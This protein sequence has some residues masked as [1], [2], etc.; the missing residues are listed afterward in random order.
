MFGVSEGRKTLGSDFEHIWEGIKFKKGIHGIHG[1]LYLG[2]I[3]DLTIGEKTM[4]MVDSSKKELI[5]CGKPV[6]L[7]GFTLICGQLWKD[8]MK[9]ACSVCKENHK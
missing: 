4:D 2:Q 6:D 7:D 5:Y 3:G 8:G 1:I 9:F